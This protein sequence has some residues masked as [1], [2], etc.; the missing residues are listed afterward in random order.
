MLSHIQWINFLSIQCW[1]Q[2]IAT[3]THESRSPCNKNR[4]NVC[5]GSYQNPG[6]IAEPIWNIR[7]FPL[8]KKRKEKRVSQR[9]RTISYRNGR[10][11]WSPV[12]FGKGTVIL[13][14]TDFQ[15]GYT[16]RGGGDILLSI[17][18]G[19]GVKRVERKSMWMY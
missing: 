14:S 18:V 19:R 6:E 17:F 15:N 3:L 13:H 5:F 2:I 10:T 16:V 12:E 11:S 1:T 9:C 4:E 7:P 8:K